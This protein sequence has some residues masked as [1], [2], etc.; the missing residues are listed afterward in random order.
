MSGQDWEPV[1]FHKKKA[2]KA[3]VQY[4]PLRRRCCVRLMTR[5]ATTAR[6]D[7]DVDMSRHGTTVTLLALRYIFLERRYAYARARSMGAPDALAGAE[8]RL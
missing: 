8:C 6:H 2:G 3:K 1:T 5:R 7:I 4:P